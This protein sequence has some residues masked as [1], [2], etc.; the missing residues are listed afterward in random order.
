[1]E[2]VLA[3]G[4]AA[5]PDRR[6]PDVSALARAFASTDMAPARPV[7]WPAAARRAFDSALET[8]R[9]LLPPSGRFPLDYAWFGLR[10]AMATD[11]A[12][13]LA[14]AEVLAGWAGPGWAAQSVA[15]R[16]ARVRSDSRMES[17]A[18]TG[19]SGRCRSAGRWAGGCSSH[20][21]G[22]EHT[23]RSHFSNCRYGGSGRLGCAAL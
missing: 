5:Q 14:A 7:H 21:G 2:A 17:K 10:A 3:R 15:A 19:L 13:L 23:R 1:V 4:L 11:D 6:F 8:V 12:E 22:S 16:V 9:R 18:I 20:S